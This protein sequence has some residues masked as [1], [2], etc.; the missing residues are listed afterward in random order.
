MS[1][2]NSKQVLVTRVDESTYRRIS[3]LLRG[4]RLDLH[5]A[6]WDS[7]TLE[8]VQGTSFDVIIIGYP[9]SR[10][11]LTRFLD[12][13]RADGAACA[14]AGLVLIT[15]DEHSEAAQGLIGKGA[16][17]F[18]VAKE[19]DTKLLAA[20]EELARPA[21]RVPVKMP[22]RIQLFSEGRPLRLMAQILNLSASGMLLRGVTQ[23]PV[24]TTFE[25]EV[26]VPEDPTPICGTAEIT[27]VTDP[28]REM[29][30]G[31]GVRFVS[32]DGSDR[33]RL[34]MFVDQ[35]LPNR[36]ASSSA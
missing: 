21:P 1:A 33:L 13:A 6:R 25:F 31:V 5:H 36:P 3:E 29:V 10:A 23:F 24:G 22:A 32:F 18:V 27:R 12:T 34:E 15:E 14:R 28:L 2:A 7:T 30:H 16:N 11:A 35:H 19:L 17:R 20:V 4:S 8:L 26:V 9:V